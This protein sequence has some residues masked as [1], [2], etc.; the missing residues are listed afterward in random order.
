VRRRVLAIDVGVAVLLAALVLILAPGVAV[1]G[2]IAI[3]VLV[4]CAISL[5]WDARRARAGR[6]RR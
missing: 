1:A 2:M 5:A 4:G 6:W 3:A